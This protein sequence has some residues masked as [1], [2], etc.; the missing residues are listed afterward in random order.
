MASLEAA[1]NR[2]A[3]ILIPFLNLS[4]GFGQGLDGGSLAQIPD[5]TQLDRPINIL[6]IAVSGKNENLSIKA[7][8]KVLEK[9]LIIKALKTTGGNRTQASRLLE[10]S[11]PSLLAK[12]KDYKINL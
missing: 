9:E 7:A 1:C 10:I 11:H 8:K 5:R 12:I 2:A 6:I 4:N 3:E